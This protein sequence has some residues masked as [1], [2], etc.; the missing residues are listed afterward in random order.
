MGGTASPS[1]RTR[2]TRVRAR[3]DGRRA[4][5]LSFQHR[6][7]T[8]LFSRRLSIHTCCKPFECAPLLSAERPGHDQRRANHSTI[9]R[10]RAVIHAPL[11][12]IVLDS[13]VA[14]DD[15][16]HKRCRSQIG[17][18]SGLATGHSE[19]GG[20]EKAKSPSE[21]GNLRYCGV[22]HG[23]Q[24]LQSLRQSPLGLCQAI[25]DQSSHQAPVPGTIQARALGAT[26]KRPPR[27]P[28]P[29][30]RHHQYTGPQHRA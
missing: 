21:S 9:E 13:G 5:L 3:R 1:V 25:T 16:V 8:L 17:L 20:C 12:A 28:S 26:S 18:C 4:K 6:V 19:H 14:A 27:W 23:T 30:P 29:S 24:E 10:H 22:C 7:T 15:D 2:C 11:A